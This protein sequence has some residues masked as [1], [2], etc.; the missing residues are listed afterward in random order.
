MHFKTS[1]FIKTKI[2]KTFFSNSKIPFKAHKAKP[3][4]ITQ[5]PPPTFSKT[6]KHSI[7]IFLNHHNFQK[8]A[9]NIIE[10]SSITIHDMTI[11]SAIIISIEIPTF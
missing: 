1:S 11:Y 9:T 8:N 10:I 2:C 6:S 5:I 3:V 7:L 4:I